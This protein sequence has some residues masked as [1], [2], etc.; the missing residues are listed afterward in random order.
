VPNNKKFEATNARLIKTAIQKEDKSGTASTV[1]TAS[2]VAVRAVK[3]VDNANKSVRKIAKGTEKLVTGKTLKLVKRDFQQK[4]YKVKKSFR[5]VKSSVSTAKKA[6]TTP[7]TPH[8]IKTGT[9]KTL[10]AGGRT[11]RTTVVVGGSGLLKTAKIGGKTYG[12]AGNAI[13]HLDNEYIATAGNAMNYSRVGTEIAGKTLTKSARGTIK[14]TKGGVRTIKS[15]RETVRSVKTLGFKRT[16]ANVAKSAVDRIGQ[17]AAK[18]SV[19]A[20]KTV[21]AKLLVPTVIVVVVTVMIIQAALAPIQGIAA[22][23]DT[24]MGWLL[25]ESEHR[26]VDET[27]AFQELVQ[28]ID[29]ILNDDEFRQEHIDALSE[30]FPDAEVGDD[31]L[32]PEEWHDFLFQTGIDETNSKIQELI[33]EAIN[34]IT[35]DEILGEISYIIQIDFDSILHDFQITHYAEFFTMLGLD[36]FPD[37]DV[38][39][40]EDEEGA[41]DDSDD[42]DDDDSSTEEEETDTSVDVELVFTDDELKENLLTSG[43][44]TAIANGF[45][46]LKNEISVT[47]EITRTETEIVIEEE[48]AETVEESEDGEAEETEEADETVTEVSFVITIT[49]TPRLTEVS[50]NPRD[51]MED[52]EGYGFERTLNKFKPLSM[53]TTAI[54]FMEEKL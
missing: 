25:R 42:G 41:A 48:T 26:N 20:L 40:E 5:A 11:L 38:D 35:D 32:I 31:G 21:G 49:F 30:E 22:L 53:L 33:S 10:A 51:F 23:I 28:R 2:D 24:T 13:S 54:Y 39:D 43:E 52:I 46:I 4:I 16:A 8:A 45:P 7:I 6:L 34:S 29:D 15:I 37:V 9:I 12:V 14:T 18:F 36:K 3:G 19:N 27:T 17:Q 1:I 44:F 47:V 50:V